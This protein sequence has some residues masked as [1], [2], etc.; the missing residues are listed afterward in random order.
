M[1][2][3]SPAK[4]HLKVPQANAHFKA[5]LMYKPFFQVN[6]Q[7]QS[8]HKHKTKHTYTHIFEQLVSS[9]SPMSK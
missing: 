2:V 5:L 4:G 7:N 3:L 6:P 8:L 9:I 1:N